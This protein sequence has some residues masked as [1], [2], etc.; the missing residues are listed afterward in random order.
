M[1]SPFPSLPSTPAVVFTQCLK[2]MDFI[3]TVL[4]SPDWGDI[5][6]AISTLSPG[7]KWGKWVKNRDYLRI[8]GATSAS[9]RGDLVNE[10]NAAKDSSACNNNLERQA[11]L[12]LISKEAGGVGINLHGA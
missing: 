9:D 8:D 1:P 3:E 5:V 10:F 7:R 11:K 6:P 12:F 2:T 4:Q